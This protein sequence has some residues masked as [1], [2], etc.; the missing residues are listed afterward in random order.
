M[1]V[2]EATAGA[3]P[4]RRNTI[5]IAVIGTAAIG[6]LLWTWTRQPAVTVDRQP[7]ASAS[8]PQSA[9][10]EYVDEQQCATCHADQTQ[11][12]HGSHH[13]LA[14]QEA[15]ATTVLGNFNDTAFTKDGI[16]TR[17]FQRDGRYWINTDGPDGKPTDYAVKY[18]FGVEPLQQYLLELD[19]GRLQAFT[20]AWDTNRK[21]WFHLYPDERIDY[22]DELHWTKPSQNWNF[23]CA[24]C[25][26]TDLK[27]NYDA[28]TQTYQTT[29]KQIDV[30]C[31][32]CHGPASRHLALVQGS[33]SRAASPA[34][35]PVDLAAPD[36][37][38]QIET[39]ARCHSRRA[40][41]WDE[42]RHGKPFLDTHLPSLLDTGLYFA[43][44]QIDGEVYE[45]GSFLQSKMHQ[46]GLRCSDCHDPHSLQ[47]R[48]PG[49]QLCTSCHNAAAPAA[50][51]SI[52]T[53]GLK[54]KDYD[55]PAHHFHKSGSPGAQ[56]V[57]CHA[58]QRTYM[59]VDPRRDHSFRIP[60]P[61]LS[62][63]LGT[64]NACNTCHTQRSSRW[65]ADAVAKWYGP[66][67]RHETTY[68]EALWA[69]RTSQPGAVTR[70]TALASDAQQPA[71]VRATALEL[72][73]AHPAPAAF[74]AIHSQLSASDALLRLAATNSLGM[75]PPERLAPLT[76]PLL[77]DAVRAVR[78][79][80]VRLTATVPAQ[81]LGA[82]QRESLMKGIREFEIAQRANADQ[83]SSWANLGNLYAS[84]GDGPASE[85]AYQTAI[86]LDPGFVPAYVNL[87]DLKSRLGDNRVAIVLLQSALGDIP[88]NAALQHALGLA[89]TR[90][91]RYDEALRELGAA[92]NGDAGNVRYAFVYGVALHDTGRKEQGIAVLEQALQRHPGDVSLLNALAS[93]A[94]ES[95]DT[96]AA[97]KY[98]SMLR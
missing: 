8:S 66:D 17:F 63:K 62:A 48:A 50:R 81:A 97:Q 85:S 55:T 59:V 37:T 45:Y 90:E 36:A 60:R 7:S 41:I 44:G 86:R 47:T 23:M 30:G 53:S 5:I 10:A 89:L 35:F 61:D 9:E 16:R 12:W 1:P 43:D 11:R 82:A 57:D 83:P 46:K 84:L 92:A 29:W 40:V 24:E 64:P 51:A 28:Q 31:Q 38:I 14:M 39:C 93:Y 79:D 4:A 75:I 87:A 69:G 95:G 52:D 94:E 71:I 19:R 70:L 65:A 49:N 78:L 42:Y 22:R 73:V 33:V 77:G 21:R 3:S 58:P 25:H 96:R 72:L 32:A 18:T 80:A 56:C 91:R 2:S 6:A 98:R 13:D 34:G 74:E 54:R 27:K 26:S 88:G 15:D 68:G 67:R 76:V 20:V